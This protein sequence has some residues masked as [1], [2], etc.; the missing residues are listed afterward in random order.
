MSNVKK[1]TSES[2]GVTIEIDY[3]K[4]IGAGQCVAVC[5][6]GVYELKDGKSTAPNIDSCIQC[7]VC[8]TSCPTGAIKHSSC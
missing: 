1:W 6:T 5:P 4:C 3:D 7:C 8:V 2:L